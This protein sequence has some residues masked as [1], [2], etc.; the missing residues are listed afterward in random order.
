MKEDF[1]NIKEDE[2]NFLITLLEKFEIFIPHPKQNDKLII[3]FLMEE[4]IPQQILND[5]KTYEQR[6]G[7]NKIGRSYGFSFLPSGIMSKIIYGFHHPSLKTL[8][9]IPRFWRDG[10]LL[11]W[12]ESFVWIELQDS[13]LQKKKGKE[14]VP[15]KLQ[16][17]QPKLEIQLPKL[18]IVS[19]G[20]GCKEVLENVCFIIE[21]V[22]GKEYPTL[23][24]Q[25]K[26]WIDY[27]DGI[28]N[29]WI[30]LSFDECLEKANKNEMIEIEGKSFIPAKNL[31]PNKIEI[32]KNEI[33]FEKYEMI[34]GSKLGSGSYGNVFKC[35]F[36]GLT[37]TYAIKEFKNDNSTSKQSF[38]QEKGILEDVRHYRIILL[39][40]S[41]KI[42]NYLYLIFEYYDQSLKDLVSKEN[43][44]NICED[45]T[46]LDLCYQVCEGIEYLH[47]KLIVHL[48]IKGGNILVEIRNNSDRN[49]EYHLKIADFGTSQKLEN[50]NSK[51]NLYFGT[52]AYMPPE[53]K[54]HSSSYNP[55][56]AD[57]YSMGCV[58]FD[59]LF[60]YGKRIKDL[61]EIEENWIIQ[62]SKEC[63]EE[64][65]NKRPTSFQ[66]KESLQKS[67]TN[68]NE[69]SN[70][71]SNK[72]IYL[73]AKNIPKI[74]TNT[75]KIS[76][77]PNL[78][79]EVR[80]GKLIGSGSFGEVFKGEW[81]GKEIAMKKLLKESETTISS[82]FMKEAQIL[83][84]INHPN[85][86]RF[87]GLYYETNGECYLCTEFVDGGCLEDFLK[88]KLKENKKLN[89]NQLLEMILTGLK[90]LKYLEK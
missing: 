13:N 81:K 60:G 56:L 90:G 15:T 57:I 72:R 25:C 82:Q 10:M 50:L 45:K 68:N 35:K 14:K 70:T 76:S 29:K 2:S 62:K 63:C 44:M 79:N 65:P 30:E 28:T 20:I 23:L 73:S 59:I 80:R 7:E 17:Q 48:D 47:S 19:V 75:D 42:G 5:W 32:T 36:E 64:E 16:Q 74:T 87:Y 55:F 66:I 69:I 34:K 6:G 43:W 21:E 18:K 3:P 12:N 77:I 41:K 38:Q 53:I 24:N 11:V 71:P 67:S 88:E 89:Q 1:P 46:K 83:Y 85:V 86:I 51:I 78:G 33:N 4:E 22:I 52:R 54:S 61:K 37:G 39:L 40:G 8:N 84:S 31:F 27:F 58:F 9:L 26:K 49:V